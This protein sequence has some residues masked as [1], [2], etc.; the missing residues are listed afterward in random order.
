MTASDTWVRRLAWYSRAASARRR[1]VT[2]RA[3]TETAASVPSASRVSEISSRTH[4]PS[5]AVRAGRRFRVGACRPVD[6]HEARP[7]LDQPP[8]QQARLAEA[9]HAV[10]LGHQAEKVLGDVARRVDRDLA[11]AKILGAADGSVVPQRLAHQRLRRHQRALDAHGGN[12]AQIEAAVGGIEE[13]GRGGAHADVELAGG[14][15]PDVSRA[16]RTSPGSTL[17][18][19]CS[20]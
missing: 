2:S 5:A 6:L 16:L 11:P 15:R 12:D 3:M 4:S 18:P 20:K 13:A 7:R 1:S 17:I 14:Q 8:R 9:R 19:S 10:A